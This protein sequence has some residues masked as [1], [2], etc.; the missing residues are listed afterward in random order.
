MRRLRTG[1]A[2]TAAALFA[3]AGVALP[4][5]ASAGTSPVTSAPAARA[6]AGVPMAD[7]TPATSKKLFTIKDQRIQ[8]PTGL[9]KSV[10]HDGIYYAVNDSGTSPRVFAIDTTGKVK[11]VLRFKA[12]LTDVEA[13]GVGRD[14]TIYVADIGDSEANRDMVEIYTIQEPENLDDQ[15]V[16]YHRFDFTY[17]DGAHDAETLLVEPGT[18]QLYVVTK[19]TKGTGM[20]YAAPPAPSR[21]GT[22]E[23]SELAPAPA[24]VITDGTFLPDGQSVVLRT[25]ADVSTVAWGDTP[26]VIARGATPFGQGETV[27]VGRTDNTVLVG[28]NSAVYQVAVPA[29][30]SAATPPAASATPKAGT[31]DQAGGSSGNSNNLTWI[32]IGA[33]VFALIITIITFPP[34]RRERRDRMAEN[35][36][37][38]GQ[39]PP[40]PHRRHQA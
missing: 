1:L 18:N 31:G 2:L 21:Q 27:A 35:A 26:T 23:L 12:D 11:A 40:A 36:R 9:A 38:T 13:V 22:N 32:L 14:G 7:P 15:D 25:S 17:P 34:G 5:T 28:A 19:A 16:K 39:S 20:I 3:L 6:A 8:K 33:A 29:K 4:T 24:G 30:K 10:K 37:L